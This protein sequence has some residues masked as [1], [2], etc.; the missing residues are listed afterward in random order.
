MDDYHDGNWLRMTAYCDEEAWISGSY[1]TAVEMQGWLKF[2]EDLAKGH[3]ETAELEFLEP[4]LEIQ[5]TN[6]PDRKIEMVVTI[7]HQPYEQ[8]H[9]CKYKFATSALARMIQD[10]KT[11][12]S[13]YP[14][15]GTPE[16]C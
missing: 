5:L 4:E 3:D 12:V 8:K 13:K 1:I 7:S 2:C 14:V 11:I 6:K 10:L 15:R 9:R 16:E